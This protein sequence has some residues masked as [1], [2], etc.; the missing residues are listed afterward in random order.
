MGNAAGG[1]QRTVS[2]RILLVDDDPL[3]VDSLGY[4]LRQ[5]GYYVATAASGA[6][7][8]ERAAREEPDLVLLDI[9]LPDGDGFAVAERLAEG[10]DSP[11]VILVSS[12][13]VAWYRSRL[14]ESSARGFIAKGDLSG[15]AVAAL[16]GRA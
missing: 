1:E 12:R 7:A 16:V 11:I 2:A 8:L 15:G 4:I 5:E 3:L 13:E 9:A 14:A 6:E 10:D